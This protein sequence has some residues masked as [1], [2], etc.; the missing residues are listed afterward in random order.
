MAIGKS[1]Y[2][3]VHRVRIF[4]NGP[5]KEAAVLLFLN[6]AAKEQYIKDEYAATYDFV[7]AYRSAMNQK[8][9][10]RTQ[11]LLHQAQIKYAI[12]VGFTAKA[13][14]HLVWLRPADTKKALDYSA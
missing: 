2:E 6:K 1:V 13:H 14:D 11:K 3:K 5:D 9:R 7:K 10:I 8:E 4:P 12:S